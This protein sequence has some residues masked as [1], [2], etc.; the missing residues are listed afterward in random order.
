MVKHLKI[1]IS[2]MFNETLLRKSPKFPEDLIRKL[3]STQD[4]TNLKSDSGE[5]VQSLLADRAIHI[6]KLT[7][8]QPILDQLRS[9]NGS[10]H[11]S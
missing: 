6:L 3:D 11:A 8:S 1:M 4:L 9:Q 7:L 5:I 2:D 10:D